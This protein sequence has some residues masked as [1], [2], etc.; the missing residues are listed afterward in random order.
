[1]IKIKKKENIKLMKKVVRK[2]EIIMLREILK[3]L[4]ICKMLL[5]KIMKK[6]IKI[7][8]MMKLRKLWKKKRGVRKKKKRRKRI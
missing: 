4:K 5:K 6:D 8:M 2:N 1:M 7:C 3:N